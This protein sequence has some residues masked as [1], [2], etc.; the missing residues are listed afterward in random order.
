MV[1]LAR[2]KFLKAGV[3]SLPALALA[4]EMLASAK[5]KPAATTQQPPPRVS[6]SVRD[7]GAKGDGSTVDTAAFQATLDRCAALGGG[8]VLVPAGDY[9]IGSVQLRSNTTLR[10]DAG[11]T[12][13][14]TDKFD[15]YAVTTVRWEGK[16]IPGHIALIYAIDAQNVAIVG[17]GKI[18]GNP[19]VGGRPRPETPLRHPALIE[20]IRCNGIH[21][22]GFST[23][24]KS[25]WSVH[26]TSSE[27]ITIKNLTIRSTGGNGDGIDID[28]CKH[29][30]ITGCDISTGDDCISLKSGRGS[31]AYAMLETT[32]DVH[33]SNCTFA[34]SLYAC[35]GIGSETSGGIR[36]VWIKDCKFTAAKTYALY[37]KSRPGRGAFIENIYADGLEVSNCTGGFLR[38]NMANSGIQDQ[39]PVPGMEG[40]P[41]A[42]NWRVSN[43]VVRDMPKLVQGTELDARKPLD[44]LW[45]TNITGTCREGIFLAHVRHAVLRDIRVTGYSGALLNTID[46]T[47]KG[48]EGARP[49]PAPPPLADVPAPATPY[50]LH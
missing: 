16:W 38:L 4:P 6:L 10:L 30:T 48:L 29:V 50:K 33:I 13:R 37:I 20:F 45:L 15:E 39:D 36:D 12:M 24:Y 43:V 26:P 3:A 34:G 17:A 31:E 14:G 42:R 27:N 25:M 28:S 21:L 9:L 18:I 32:E 7:F 35:I 47:G 5:T 41:T 22:E 40:I 1:V 19:A 49:F 8:E 46:V 2:R 11:S 23:E 44:E